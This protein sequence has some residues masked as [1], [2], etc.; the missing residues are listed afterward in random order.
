M[1]IK[2]Y[3]I[4]FCWRLLVVAAVD[5]LNPLFL[6]SV[7]LF[8]GLGCSL[9]L[10]RPV[11]VA[12]WQALL[13][14]SICVVLAI[15]VARA[16]ARWQQD[17]KDAR[18]FHWSVVLPLLP[19]A[20]LTPLFLSEL[21]YPY[22]QLRHHGDIHLGY[23]HQ[24]MYA[25]TPPENIF[26]PGYPANYYWLYHALVAAISQW[27]LLSPPL[28]ASTLN[29][30]AILSSL[31]WI[32]QTLVRYRIAS[33]RTLY[34][35]CMALLVYCAMNLH[36]PINMMA[37]ALESG[38]APISL[39]SMV[40]DGG[41][42]RLH[43]TMGKVMNFTSMTLAILAFVAALYVCVCLAQGEVGRLQLILATACIWIGLAVQP[44]GALYTVI[45]LFGGIALT[46]CM[47]WLT[48]PH[49]LAK[50]R[51]FARHMATE[52]GLGYLLFWAAISVALSPPLLGYA[53]GFSAGNA[54]LLDFNLE[55]SPNLDMQFAAVMPLIPFCLLQFAFAIRSGKVDA[56]FIPISSSLCLLLTTPLYLPDYNQYK[57][58]YFL[59]MLLAIAFALVM[60]QMRA[61]GLRWRAAARVL[62][63]LLFAL[64]VIKIA[65]VTRFYLELAN[66]ESFEYD[67][68]HVNY[69]AARGDYGLAEALYWIRENTAHDAIVVLPLDVSKFAHTVHE[70][71][72]YVRKS[73]GWYTDQIAAYGK[74]V[75]RVTRLYK[76]AADP[77]SDASLLA[78]MAA[79]LPG[80]ALYAVVRGDQVSLPLMNKRGAKLVFD[81]GYNAAHVYWLNPQG[82]G[83]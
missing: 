31:L 72:T 52:L 74:R 20:V 56:L 58:V 63:G 70:R 79:E 15:L 45:A 57:G 76:S 10:L 71:M 22:L 26:A 68:L 9:T 24:L 81:G 53:L 39:G 51:S 50:L 27:T 5:V 8:F 35:G 65:F 69:P 47:H 33:S 30:A 78:E 17:A 4:D 54:L 60:R 14:A 41:I 83:E 64:V 13:I 12:D 19:V 61:S 7:A 44:I 32:S 42:T 49:Q 37:I 73:Q 40:S 66:L 16:W 62:A 55:Q 1:S 38:E 59:A 34:L 6:I 18:R 23:I 28:V 11:A 80:R 82:M 36:G 48:K 67:G 77:V 43:S 21:T 75:A 29:I 46:A 2:R 3:R 25:E